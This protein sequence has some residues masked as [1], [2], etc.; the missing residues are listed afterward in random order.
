MSKKK[1][2]II[3]IGSNTIRLVVYK[4]T[5]KEGL[6]EI[7]N[8]KTAA[9][10]RS[11]IQPTGEMSEEGIELLEN[12]LSS[13]KDILE[14]YGVTNVYAAA[15]AAIRQA[16]NQQE[17]VKRMKKKTG[18]K[19]VV[20]SG[21]E[22]AYFGFLAVV[23]SMITSSA[24]TIDI[25][26]GSTE[27]TLFIDKKLQK[28]HS[29]PFG[30]VSLKQR[31]VKGNII[32]A[33]EKKELVSFLLQ[34]F[35][36][37]PWIQGVQLPVIGIGGSA[38]NVAQI[39]QQQTDY[40]I[41][42]V[43]QYEVSR[44]DLSTLATRIEALSFEQLK[45]LDGLSSDRAD[46]ILPAI[47]VFKS[48]MDVVESQ[49]FQVTSKGLREGIIINKILQD[50]EKVF[51]KNNVFE[52]N[53]QR[54]VYEYGRKE[55]EVNYLSDLTE[56]LYKECCRLELMPFSDKHLQTL[57]RAAKLYSLG[58]YIEMSSSS[59]HTFY[60]IANQTIEGITHRERVKLALLASYKNRDFFRRFSEPFLTWFSNEELNELR[61]F[62]ALLK[63]IYALNISKRLIVSSIQLE[64]INDKIQ[65]YIQTKTNATAEKYQ[66][67][68]QKKH[69]ERV[70]KHEVQLNFIEER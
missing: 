11:Y 8:I 22:E 63:F 35:K 27:I 13:M 10:L 21:E 49:A 64:L 55:F 30:T 19:I 6:R 38:R 33:D 17:I 29:F 66:A 3:D 18:I 70:V 7:S 53:I 43:H 1:T 50:D 67:G 20:L 45:R 59:Q 61:D 69:L 60:L 51:D 23:H 48:L 36:S 31:F 16:S 9:R 4:Y 44:S 25:G 37:L 65:I 14:E 57:S 68:K 41:S 34:Q 54:L 39:L 15:T 12:T 28:T 2:A 58:E 40:P 62:G 5:P 52:V 24:V 26:G 47:E 46:T 32:T 56:Q 42:G